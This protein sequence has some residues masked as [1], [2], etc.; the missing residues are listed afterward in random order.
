M[1]RLYVVLLSVCL[2]TANNYKKPDK[3]GHSFYDTYISFEMLDQ[4][5]KEDF[6]DIAP[7]TEKT[8]SPNM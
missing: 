5:A 4:K 6:I 3:D 2:N 7:L 8:N 1:P